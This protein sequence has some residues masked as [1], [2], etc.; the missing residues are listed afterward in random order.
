MTQ[1]DFIA[2][3]LSLCTSDHHFQDFKAVANKQRSSKLQELSCHERRTYSVKILALL[4]G[5]HTLQSKREQEIQSESHQALR[6][7]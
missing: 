3:H 6:A 4:E 2:L 5:L 1:S 7:F